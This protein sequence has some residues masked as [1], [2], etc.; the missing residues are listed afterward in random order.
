MAT[1]TRR[2][3]RSGISAFRTF[4]RERGIPL[5]PASELTLRYFCAH[6]SQSVT[7]ATIKVYLA[8]IRLLHLEH[9]FTDPMKDRPL[10]DYLCSGIRRSGKSNSRSRLPITVAHL[11]TIKC[12]LASSSYSSHD[13]LLYWA[14]FTLAF[15]GFLRASE[16]CC[17]TRKKYK[18]AKHLLLSDVKVTPDSISLLL[19]SSK[20]DQFGKS[21]TLL[22][23][24]TRSSTCPVRAM[25][26]FLESRSL[27]GPGPL[28]TFSC[29][30]FLTRT[31]VSRTTKYFLATAGN[32]PTNYSS[33]SYR[34]E[35][36]Q[37][38]VSQS[39]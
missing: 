23:G 15:Y 20:T 17:P 13:K 29:R 21:H 24:A 12:Q 9:G 4:C 5:L 30:D 25:Q 36:L 28:F 16:Y 37:R 7:Y 19:K 1:S 6:L 18:M 31:A 39:T 11:H 26:K 2:T 27:F 22:I 32:D 8:G 14:A 35:L 34:V 33:H 3:Y 38:L 10:L